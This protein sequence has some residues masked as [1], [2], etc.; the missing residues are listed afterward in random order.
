MNG[1]QRIPRRPGALAI[2]VAATALALAACGGSGDSPQVASLSSSPA[3]NSPAASTSP[4]TGTSP[5]A[6]TSPGTGTV[7]EAANLGQLVDEWAAC[8]RA[9]G[10]P[11]QADP[12]IDAG[13]VINIAVPVNVTPAGDIHNLTG[14]CSEYLAQAQ[15]ELRAANPVAPPPDQAEI[16]TYTNCMRTNGVPNYPYPTP[17]SDQLNFNAAG[18]NADSPQFMRANDLCG[19][20]IGAPTWWINGTNKPGNIEVTTAGMHYPLP[21]QPPAQ[22]PNGG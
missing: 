10:D 4:E 14:T 6:G 12:T 3:A 21:S 2:L 16:L 9:H 5:E 1:N 8:E 17:G 19:K 7:Q 20:R 13:G 11:D 18:V 15:S 22:V